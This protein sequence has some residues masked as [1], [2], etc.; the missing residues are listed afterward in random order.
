MVNIIQDVAGVDFMTEKDIVTELLLTTKNVLNRY[1]IAIGETAN[2][3]LRETLKKHINKLIDSQ[4]N[5]INYAVG[6]GYYRPYN[7]S[8]QFEDDLKKAYT[9]LDL[10]PWKL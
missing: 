3:E 9:T 5:L 10:E 6:K 7:P 1:C 8:E 2:P 4:S